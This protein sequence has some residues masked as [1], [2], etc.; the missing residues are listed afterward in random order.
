MITRY[1]WICRDRAIG[2]PSEREFTKLTQVL[3]ACG[4]HDIV[5]LKCIDPNFGIGYAYFVRKE[6]LP[7]DFTNGITVPDKY[8]SET[9]IVFERRGRDALRSV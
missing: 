2:T 8:F 7:R 9:R 5:A 1:K 3:D 6:H 4:D